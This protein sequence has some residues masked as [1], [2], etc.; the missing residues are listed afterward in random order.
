VVRSLSD[1]SNWTRTS[2]GLAVFGFINMVLF[3]TLS[4]P[5][6]TVFNVVEEQSNETLNGTGYDSDVSGVIGNLRT[7]FGLVFVFSMFGLALWFFLGSHKQ[8]YEDY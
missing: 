2:V 4:S 6:G 7:I 1:M 3:L 8:E 5:V